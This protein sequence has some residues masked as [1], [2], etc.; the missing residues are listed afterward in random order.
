MAA[1]VSGVQDPTMFE[2]VLIAIKGYLNQLDQWHTILQEIEDLKQHGGITEEQAIKFKIYTG[3]IRNLT[4]PEAVAAT[5]AQVDIDV[6]DAVYKGNIKAVRTILA[7]G[8]LVK[9][10]LNRVGRAGKTALGAAIEQGNPAM[11]ALLVDSPY[12]DVNNTGQDVPSLLLA[13]RKGKKEIAEVLLNKCPEDKILNI[14]AK[15]PASGDTP[16]FLAVINGYADVVEALLH[17]GANVNEKYRYGHCPLH[18]AAESGHVEVVKV[19]LQHNNI[20]V[21]VKDPNGCSPLHMAA[22]QGHVA[23]VEVLLQHNNIDK[24]IQEQDEWTPL[25]MA[26][27]QNHVGVVNA[28][29]AKKVKVDIKNTYNMT[30]LDIAIKYHHQACITALEAAGGSSND[31]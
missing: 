18:I 22:Q 2:F 20:D 8:H 31:V 24:N 4:L 12:V 14:E 27:H 13:L 1:S 16:L 29:L 5:D 10:A 26:V 23:L 11:V 19:L 30:P 17:K 7:A 28:L 3:H 25:H 15:D 9:D 21:N 6:C